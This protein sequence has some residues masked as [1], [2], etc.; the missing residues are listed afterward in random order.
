MT[1]ISL[2]TQSPLMTED[3]M[4]TTGSNR[5]ASLIVSLGLIGLLFGPSM[6]CDDAAPTPPGGF[7]TPRSFSLAQGPVCMDILE[8]TPGAVRPDIREC[9]EGERGAI[10]LIANQSSDEI[11]VVDM[12]RDMGGSPPRN[13]RLADLDPST[14]AVNGVKVGRTPVDVAVSNGTTAY[15]LSQSDRSLSVINLWVLDVLPESITFDSAPREVAVS[16]AMNG[17]D[18]QIVAALSN[19]SRLWVHPSVECDFGDRSP[20]RPADGCDPVPSQADGESFELPGS[21]SDIDVGPAGERAWVTYSDANFASVI[22]LTQQALDDLGGA[23]IEGDAA[24]CEAR[25]VGL[26]FDCSNGVDDDGDGQIDRADPQCYGPRG[27]ESPDGIGRSATGNCSN[28]LDDDDDGLVDR[29]DPDCLTSAGAEDEPIAEDPDL[30]CNDGRDNDGDG[31]IDYPA[32]PGCYGEVGRT[33]RESEPTGFT[34]LSVGPFGAFVYAVDR[35]ND[36]IIVVDA[37]H[38]ELIDTFDAGG[39]DRTPF[40]NR[41]GIAVSPSPTA[42]EGTIDRSVVWRDPRPDVCDDDQCL[43]AIVRY[44]YG[45]FVASDDGYAYNINAMSTYCEVD[46]DDTGIVDSDE[47]FFGSQALMDSPENRCVTVPDFPIDY[48]AQACTQLDDCLDCRAQGLSGLNCAASVCADFEATR[49]ACFGNRVTEGEDVRLAFNPE[50][51]VQDALRT[52]SRLRGLGSCDTPTPLVDALR[53]RAGGGADTSCTSPLRPQPIDATT[54]GQDSEEDIVADILAG[55]F[56]RASLIEQSTARLASG[57][58]IDADEQDALDVSLD[59]FEVAAQNLMT[60]DDQAVVDESWTVTYEGVL[61]DTRRSDAVVSADEP[62]VVSVAGLDMCAAGVEA[63]D[64][65]TIRSE[66]VGTDGDVPEQCEGFVDEERG[67]ALRTWTIDEV[68]PRELVL[69]VIEADGDAED[70]PAF[71]DELPS[72][73]CFAQGLRIEIR[74]DDEW[75]VVGDRTGFVSQRKS[76]LGTCQPRFGAEHP[77][78]GSR[79]ETGELF[80]GPYLSFF[81]YPGAAEDGE[82]IEPVRS[83]DDELAYRFGVQRAFQADRFR[84]TT[85]LPTEVVVTQGIPAGRFLIIP[86]PSQNLLYIRNLNLSGEQADFLLE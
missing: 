83:A 12:N 46:A 25:R 62:G 39:R 34:S 74:A 4:M 26:T 81:L 43:H 63:G 6:G 18:G 56:D 61:P 30:A 3:P 15:A 80:E 2:M 22:A 77:R 85:L 17:D 51:E 47:F 78:V 69:S 86:D 75:T 9:D 58:Q 50:F 28:G 53:D 16:P 42:V 67:Q 10:G 14:P 68:R 7:Q 23:C 27:A 5:F 45:A 82:P 24:P 52:Q 71:A 21:V 40:S 33:E 41:L 64:R 44:S 49:E 76:V 11:S 72:R 1:L 65:L 38:L 31:A 66:P 8:P 55:R 20:A 36:Q 54:A 79:V 73:E 60:I 70:Q 19:P 29:E 57:E 37:E 32:D 48:D 13:P 59:P 35:A 84:T